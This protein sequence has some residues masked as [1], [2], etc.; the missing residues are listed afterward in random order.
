M[1]LLEAG[2]KQS[3]CEH[4]DICHTN[5]RES[6][7]VDE[8][9]RNGRRYEIPDACRSTDASYKVGDICEWLLMRDRI[10]YV[11]IVSWKWKEILNG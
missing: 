11:S 3:G 1:L 9:D 6:H 2:D 7:G 10:E 5:D 4:G 8:A